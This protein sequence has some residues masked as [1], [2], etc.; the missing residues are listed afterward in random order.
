M[1]LVT[2]SASRSA[3]A[4]SSNPTTAAHAEVVESFPMV[5]AWP[6]LALRVVVFFSNT[7]IREGHFLLQ[8]QFD[9]NTQAAIDAGVFGAPSYCVGGEIFWGQ[10]RLDF[11]ERKLQCD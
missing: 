4:D 3:F 2:I 6:S 9:A 1:R 10:D 8:D 11:L 7:N 5:Y